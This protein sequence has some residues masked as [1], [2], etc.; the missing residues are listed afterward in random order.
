MDTELFKGFAQIVGIILIF[1]GI[2]LLIR[3]KW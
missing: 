2:W 1:A 3:G